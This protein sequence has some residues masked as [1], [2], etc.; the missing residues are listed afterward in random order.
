MRKAQHQRQQEPGKRI[1]R[2][3]KGDPEAEQQRYKRQQEADNEV[4]QHIPGFET[5]P[6]YRQRDG[7]LAAGGS[8][9]GDDGND[10]RSAG[11]GLSERAAQDAGS[12]VWRSIDGNELVRIVDAEFNDLR[13]RQVNPIATR[14]HKEEGKAQ[15][16]D[17]DKAGE[18][19]ATV[20]QVDREKN[21]QESV[22]EDGALGGHGLKSS[23]GGQS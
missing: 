22:K 5:G 14:F 9:C 6:G 17:M 21:G 8:T 13:S 1:A 20:E 2:T 18:V 7:S 15:L 12:G 10:Q 19:K 4:T 16:L 23:P 3:A 11:F